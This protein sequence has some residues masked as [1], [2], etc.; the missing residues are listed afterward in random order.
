MQTQPATALLSPTRQPIA[1]R[2]APRLSAAAALA[3]TT[4]LAP[5]VAT[6]QTVTT[7]AQSYGVGSYSGGEPTGDQYYGS[8]NDTVTGIAPMPDGG[9]VVAGQ[10]DLPKFGSGHTGE[11]APGAL[12]R[13]GKDGRILWQT[14][15]R[16]ENDR[17]N[18]DGSTTVVISGIKSLRTDAAGNIF[19][20]GGKGNPD[21][22]G[23]S[24]FAAKFS[25]EGNLIWENSLAELRFAVPNADGSNHIDTEGYYYDICMDVTSDGGIIIGGSVGFADP[26][27]RAHTGAYL[28]KFNADGS[29]SFHREYESPNQYNG[30]N[31]VCPLPGG[32]GYVALM[33]LPDGTTTPWCPEGGH[34]HRRGRQP[35]CPTHFLRRSRGVLPGRDHQCD[36][37][38][39]RQRFSPRQ[40]G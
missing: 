11:N 40:F 7:W 25:P 12:V 23:K 3:A 15:L 24:P 20:V 33:N 21:N 5:G 18:A 22:Q 8:G 32:V 1:T 36:R 30:T 31:S 39:R 14:L 13:Y 6:A 37:K 17:I 38:R 2:T 16:Q 34:T 26:L 4:L 35:R 9:V 27:G 29:L 19:V 10:L 28:A